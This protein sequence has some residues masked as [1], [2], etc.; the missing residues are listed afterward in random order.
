M[1]QG[2]RRS[3]AEPSGRK[4]RSWIFV[5]SQCAKCGYEIHRSYGRK[6]PWVHANRSPWC[7]QSF[8]QQVQ[9]TVGSRQPLSETSD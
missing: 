9:T 1:V 5:F 3:T 4:T 2:A 7:P 6:K 8:E